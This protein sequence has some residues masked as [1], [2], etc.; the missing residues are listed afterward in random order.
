MPGAIN[1]VAFVDDDDDLRGANVQSLQLAGFEVMGFASA[2]AAATALPADFPGVVV[3]DIR[4]P[5]MDGRQLFRELRERDE[6]LP[7]ILVTGHADLAEAVEAMHEGAYDYLAKPFGPDRLISSVRRALDKRRLVLDNRRLIEAAT[8]A[9][10]D[11][12]LIGETAT[13]ERLRSTIRQVAGANIDVLIEGETG[14]GKEVVAR[15]LHRSSR[16]R[17][18]PF[19]PVAFAAMPDQM[20]ESELFGHEAGAFNGAIRRRVGRIE[21]S[22]RGTLFLDEIESMPQ[23]TQGKLLRVLE[24][25]EV[26]PLGGN[27]VRSVDLR[28]VAAAKG[29]LRELVDRGEF[30][31]DLFYRL[32][33]VRIRIAPLRERRADIPL[34]FGHF[35]TEAAERFKRDR[36][37]LTDSVRL[38]LLNHDWP[39][40]VRELSHFAERV[41]LGVADLGAAETVEQFGSLPRR[42][43][44]FEEQLLRESLDIH[45]GEVREAAAALGIP[46]KTLYDKINKYGIDLKQHRSQQ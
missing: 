46:R 8:R 14:T 5:G 9:E 38:H 11:G 40:N 23:A 3:T 24:E 27:D 33:V 44:A 20:V 2:E 22:H 37:K 39:G 13:I 15:L 12:A 21:V 17:S 35:L 6:D 30:R 42:M 18:Q 1:Q 45:G 7:V 32:D 4:M 19:V 28:I 41:A 29:D 31:S 26:T 16:R 36:P 25:R 34:L 43:D 10:A